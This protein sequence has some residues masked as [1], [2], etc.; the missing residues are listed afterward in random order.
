MCL[1]L[2]DW[3]AFVTLAGEWGRVT[4]FHIYSLAKG[5]EIGPLNRIWL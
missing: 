2:V 4:L 3:K 5:L 1:D